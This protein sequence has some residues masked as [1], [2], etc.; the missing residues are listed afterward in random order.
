MWESEAFPD[1]YPSPYQTMVAEGM[2]PQESNELC[3]T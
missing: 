3:S 1:L 2:C